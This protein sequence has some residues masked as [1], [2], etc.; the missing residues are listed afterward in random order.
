MDYL[1]SLTYLILGGGTNK[2]LLPHCG[3][4]HTPTAEHV[5][6][7]TAPFISSRCGP[8]KMF[9]RV[10]RQFTPRVFLPALNKVQ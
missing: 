3:N 6:Y 5:G 7:M 8:L 9:G 1:P 10:I 4:L 2:K